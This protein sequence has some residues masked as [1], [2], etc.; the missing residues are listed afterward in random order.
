MFPM[1]S[2]SFNNGVSPRERLCPMTVLIAFSVFFFFVFSK[3]Q[4]ISLWSTG[5]LS[6][7]LQLDPLTSFSVKR[8]KTVCARVRFVL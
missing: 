8:S 1:L 2:C 5:E 6:F 4:N 3:F 7:L